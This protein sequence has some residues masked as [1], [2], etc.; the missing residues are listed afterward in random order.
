MLLRKSPTTPAELA[1]GVLD[2]FQIA[3]VDPKNVRDFVGHGSTVIINALTERKGARPAFLTTKGYRDM[4]IIQRC[5]RTDM[6]NFVCE[7]P[8]PFVARYLCAEV[9]ER[10]N[11]KGEELSGLSTNDVRKAT[12]QLLC[13]LSDLRQSVRP[14]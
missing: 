6:Y 10:L 11:F 2:A 3:K 7:K 5:D 13:G 8:R 12:R 14:C 9:S 4:L 1:E